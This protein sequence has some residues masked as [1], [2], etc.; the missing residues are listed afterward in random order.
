[1]KEGRKEGCEWLSCGNRFH[2]IQILPFGQHQIHT[3]TPLGCIV[4]SVYAAAQNGPDRFCIEPKKTQCNTSQY[5]MIYWVTCGLGWSG[6][7]WGKMKHRSGCIPL[8]TLQLVP[9]WGLWSP[10]CQHRLLV[11]TRDGTSAYILRPGEPRETPE[12][13][14]LWEAPEQPSIGGCGSEHPA[15]SPGSA[16]YCL[17]IA[18]SSRMGGEERGRRRG[19]KGPPPPHRSG[20]SQ[21]CSTG[22]RRCSLSPYR[23]CCLHRLSEYSRLL[24]I[25]G[26]NVP[27]DTLVVCLHYFFNCFVSNILCCCINEVCLY[28]VSRT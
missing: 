25:F 2:Y 14:V 1:M 19:E 21:R 16:S 27:C 7:R 9:I 22:S 4:F 12:F 18:L 17:R 8:L 5:Y 28:K 24:Q 15:A 13:G 11:N 3:H 10:P 6:C 26:E 23:L 20:Q